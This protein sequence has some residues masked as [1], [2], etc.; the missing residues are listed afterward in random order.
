[1]TGTTAG[2]G[3]YLAESGHGYTFRVRARDGNGNWSPWN[4]GATWQPAPR[5]GVGGFG[6]VAVETL[7]MRSGPSTASPA[8]ATLARND[9]LAVTGG[10]HS[11][12][13]Y[14]WYQVTGPLSEWGPVSG[15]DRKSVV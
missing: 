4:V 2:A 8:V 9:L 13:G 3:T 1:L 10:P 14:T 15:S 5:L 6:R 11:A 12:E 7:T